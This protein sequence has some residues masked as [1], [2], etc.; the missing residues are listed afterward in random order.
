MAPQTK[1]P[2][3]L[4]PINFI[5]KQSSKSWS[6]NRR[7]QAPGSLV[8]HIVLNDM[9]A[10]VQTDSVLLDHDLLLHERVHLLLEEVHLVNVVD[11]ELLKVFLQIRDILNNLLQNVIGR[12]GRMVL[13]SCA[14]GP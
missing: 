10:L 4:F 2:L 13:E 9:D 14:L 11:L 6:D 7:T 12:F 1:Y 3:Q 5:Y 8:A